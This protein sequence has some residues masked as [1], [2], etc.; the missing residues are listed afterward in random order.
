METK[1]IAIGTSDFI[2]SEVDENF[3]NNEYLYG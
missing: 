2:I 1:K 3:D